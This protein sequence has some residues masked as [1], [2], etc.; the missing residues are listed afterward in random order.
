[1]LKNFCDQCEKEINFKRYV[2]S[3]HE[4][5]ENNETIDLCKEC[6]D[7]LGLEKMLAPRRGNN[8]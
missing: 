7:E 6:F 5:G 8:N 4:L 2:V 1:M 3:W